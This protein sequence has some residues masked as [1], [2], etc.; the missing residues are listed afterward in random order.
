MC[1]NFVGTHYLF[2]QV[3]RFF[4]SRYSICNNACLGSSCDYMLYSTWQE[5]E[6]LNFMKSISLRISYYEGSS[7]KLKIC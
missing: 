1:Q 4:L 7:V 5:V 3:Q 6:E 2:L